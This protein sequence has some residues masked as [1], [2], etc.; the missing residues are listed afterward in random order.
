[1][2][3]I[4][5]P[6]VSIVIPVFNGS[7]YMRE[8]IDSAIAQTYQNI[9]IIVVNDGSNDNGKTREIALSYGDKIRYFEKENGGVSTA[10]NLGIKEMKGEYFSWLSHDDVYYP[11]KVERQVRELEGLDDKLTLIYSDYD[12]VDKNLILKYVVALGLHH[13]L[14]K[15]N[16]G[17]YATLN[18]CLNGCTMMINKNVFLKLGFFDDNLKNTQDYD[19]WFK[20]FKNNLPIRYIQESLVKTRSHEDQGSVKCLDVKN[21]CDKLW[22]NM[23]S[24]LSSQ[25]ISQINGNEYNFLEKIYN[26]IK[27]NNNQ[28][29]ACEYILNKMNVIR[30]NNL[31]LLQNPLIS[32]IISCYNQSGSIENAID[33]ALNN[34]YDNIEIIVIN[35]GSTD[36]STDVLKKYS[37][38]P[39]IKIFSQENSGVSEVRNFGISISNGDFIQILDGDD[40]LLNGKLQNQINQF[41]EMPNIDISYTSFFYYHLSNNEE[42]YPKKESLDLGVKQF[43]SFLFNWQLPISIPIHCFLFKKE[44][45]NNIKF[46]KK[47]KIC[48]DYIVYLEMAKNNKVFHFLELEGCVYNIHSNN[49]HQDSF[50]ILKDASSSLCYIK[51]NFLDSYYKNEFIKRKTEYLNI[52][53][54]TY[55]SKSD[56]GKSDL[57]KSDF[58]K[59]IYFFGFLIMNIIYKSN[60]LKAKIFKNLT[61]FQKK[62]KKNKTKYY[63]C[64]ILFLKIKAI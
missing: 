58:E 42:I 15:L 34:G 32:I 43:E 8:A 61:L 4:F 44:C 51:N 18:A 27:T 54:K 56:L 13:E 59:R 12:I 25:E 17:L 3:D 5:Q 57:G 50:Q 33:S 30:K 14:R 16:F 60:N 48:E 1:M 53:F 26:N 23:V 22:I 6:L 63:F 38:N 55:F 36:N 28:N 47:L 29:N 49:S 24:S 20:I 39:K 41:Q 11:N 37:I 64:G 62:T 9:E 31:E 46:D 7:N 52:I 10:L 45:F 19:L 2:S 35:D 40:L 21:E